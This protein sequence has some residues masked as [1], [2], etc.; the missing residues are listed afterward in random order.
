MGGGSVPLFLSHHFPQLQVE[1]VD[2]D[3]VVIAAAREAM[4]FPAD[5]QRLR[6]VEADAATRIAQL[7]AQSPGA[8]DLVV[9]DVFDG[10]D[11]TPA[12]VSS[13][14]FLGHL[15]AALHPEHGTA[16][17][18]LHGGGPGA[19]TSLGRLL[20]RG[21]GGPGFQ[22]DNP[23]GEAV[24]R[25]SRAYRDALIPPW[26]PSGP[27]GGTA[28]TISCAS[29]HNIIVVVSRALRPGSAS[30]LQAYETVTRLREAAEEVAE[31][32]GYLFST[33]NR[34]VRGF[35]PV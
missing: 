5:S 27:P 3:P 33:T 25:I 11:A 28:Y 1:A 10:E 32:A 20:G 8:V 23:A 18:N 35:Q 24:G 34:A 17:V 26:K 22:V 30:G 6:A 13:P 21:S 31:R 14:E 16:I 7:A 4:G 29:Q 19:M 15:A 2:L 12:A 9:V